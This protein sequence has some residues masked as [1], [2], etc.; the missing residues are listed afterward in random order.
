MS[1]FSIPISNYLP[2]FIFPR[3]KLKKRGAN[4]NTKVIAQLLERLCFLAQGKDKIGVY[5][6]LAILTYNVKF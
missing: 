6:T 4:Y 2:Q 5:L 1:S 3:I